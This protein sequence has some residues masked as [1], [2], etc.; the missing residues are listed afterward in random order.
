MNLQFI[1]TLHR[2]IGLAIALI[3]IV[4]CITGIL[5]NHTHSLSLAKKNAPEWISSY[6]YGVT[7]QEN[8]I[9]IDSLEFRQSNHQIYANHTTFGQ[10]EM[11]MIDA[12]KM[13][14][15]II[16]LCQDKLLLSTFE[17]ELIES[18]NQSSGLPTPMTAVFKTD[19]ANNI[20]IHSVD[21]VVNLNLDKLLITA[22][23]ELP[24]KKDI[25]TEFTSVTLE[26][27]ILDLHS[28]RFIGGWGI[29]LVD[30]GALFLLIMVFTGWYTWYKKQKMLKALENEDI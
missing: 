11:P 29:L 13:E 7:D 5:L 2:W 19:I 15:F 16:L 17:G 8:N 28:G 21:K 12:V 30:L 1:Q 22:S 10:C 4:L 18:I 24:I 23:K 6:F 3:V 9:T 25:N 26:R 20:K 27:W 14:N